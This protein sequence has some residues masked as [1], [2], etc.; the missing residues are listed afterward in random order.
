MI[1]IL[2]QLAKELNQDDLKYMSAIQFF[3]KIL[4]KGEIIIN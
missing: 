1:Y 3:F 2:E 4:G